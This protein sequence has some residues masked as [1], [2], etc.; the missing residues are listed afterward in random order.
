MKTASNPIG[1]PG[2]R[3]AT[4]EGGGTKVT[5][6]PQGN[7]VSI[8]DSTPYSSFFSFLL[9]C[10]F[11]LLFSSSFFL[12]FFSSFFSFFLFSL[13]LPPFYF[14]FFPLSTI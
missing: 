10:F 4:P 6:D 2:G 14:I 1:D 11:F 5:S 9:L 12:L 7:P 3:R 13:L 8:T